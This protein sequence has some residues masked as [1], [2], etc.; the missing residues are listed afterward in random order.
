MPPHSISSTPRSDFWIIQQLRRAKSSIREKLR[1][2]GRPSISFI[3][4]TGCP[5][6]SV[7]TLFWDFSL[8][9]GCITKS[10]EPPIEWC[11][12]IFWRYETWGNVHSYLGLGLKQFLTKFKKFKETKFTLCPSCLPH[13][14]PQQI[15]AL[16]FI[17]WLNI[18]S[19]NEW[20]F[21]TF[22]LWTCANDC[23]SRNSP[24]VDQQ[25]KE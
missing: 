1:W 7:T 16:P 18:L 2:V 4:A 3:L 8:I 24:W 21:N 22:P 23:F 6:V 12:A 19:C 11:S 15:Y 25:Q 13:P 5:K 17:F 14:P 10:F 9:C 20:S